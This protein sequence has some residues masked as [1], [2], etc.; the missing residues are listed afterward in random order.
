[1]RRRFIVLLQS[2]P[3]S[4]T[5]RVLLLLVVLIWLMIRGYFN[6]ILL[7]GNRVPWRQVHVM[8]RSRRRSSLVVRQNGW[9]G[10]NMVKLVR[11]PMILLIHL[12]MRKIILL[13]GRVMV[14]WRCSL[15][16]VPKRRFIL[17]IFFV[18]LLLIIVVSLTARSPILRRRTLLVVLFLPVTPLIILVNVNL[19]GS[20]KSLQKRL[21][22][23]RG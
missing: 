15:L 21:L 22:G 6:V 23:K 10:V 9:N 19:F 14:I 8:V 4:L 3:S 5:L 13:R 2:S 12:L 18:L 1:M 7:P 20:L 11:L 17:I 16:M